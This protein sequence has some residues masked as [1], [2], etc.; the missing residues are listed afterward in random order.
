MTFPAGFI[1]GAATAA[2]QVEG[3][4]AEGGRGPSI[5][6]TFAHTPGRTRNSDTGDIAA[7]HYHRWR[8]DV[9]LM[10]EL[11]LQA[12]R[13]SVSWPR[14]QPGGRGPLNPEGLA[15]YRGLIDELLARGIRPVLTLYHWDLPQAL[16]DRGGWANRDTAHAFAAYARAMARELGQGVWLW[17]TLDEPWCIAFLGHASGEH[18]PGH[19]NAAEALAVAHHLNLAHG[20]A[21]RAI[22]EEL[23]DALVSVAL[24]LHVTRPADEEDSRHLE[25]VRS[26]DLVGNHIFLG[27]M[28]EG[29]YPPDLVASTRHLTDWSFVHE[30]D[31]VVTRQ[32]LDMLGVTYRTSTVVRPGAARSP[33]WVGADDVEFLPPA[34]PLTAPGWGIDP[35]GLYDLLTAL[36]R[37]YPDLPLIVTANGAAF[38]DVVEEG[39]GVPAVRDHRRIEYISAHLAVLER[40]IE[41]G[42]DV[43]GFL[44]WSLLD[45]FEW[46][47]GYTQRFGL[48]HVD[49][50]TGTRLVKESGR[51][52]ARVIAEHRAAHAP[53]VQPRERP[54][55]PGI[56][57]LRRKRQVRNENRVYLCPGCN[58]PIPAGVAHVVAWSNEHLFGSDAALAERRH[59]HTACWRRASGHRS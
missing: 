42:V 38:D 6:D 57:G 40:A 1:L 4:A 49:H 7:D 22:R 16:Q 37:A 39:D 34:G 13:F 35:E 15:F 44:L 25:A 3:A 10:R 50:P 52:Y 12:Y 11:G 33:R 20:L 59:W 9:A 56:L 43:R 5:W 30:G 26:I 14:V 41:A 58:H 2:Y 55:R 31:L 27:P 51:W 48:V 29:S 53:A 18:A 19:A 32:R 21:A 46:A 36:D 8:S 23:P 17:V 47:E 24:N 54:S 28:L 45:G